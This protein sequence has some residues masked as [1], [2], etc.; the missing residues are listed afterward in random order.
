MKGEKVLFREGEIQKKV[1]TFAKRNQE[2][3]AEES[4]VQSCLSEDDITQYLGHVLQEVRKQKTP[5]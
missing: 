5:R 2:K 4:G 3:M 1:L